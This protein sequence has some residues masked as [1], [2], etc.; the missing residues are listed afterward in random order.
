M[1]PRKVL[2]GIETADCLPAL[3]LAAEE[4]VRRGSGVHLMHVLPTL[5]ASHPQI[6]ELELVAGEVQRA[7]E[8]VVGEA[9]RTMQR[10]LPDDLVV[11]TE[12]RHGTVFSCLVEASAHACLLVLQHRDTRHDG[13]SHLLPT[14]HPVVA[15][16]H[17]AV[18]VVPQTWHS[19]ESVEPPLVL[20]GVDDG[21]RS[22]HVAQLAMAEAARRHARVRLVH[23]AKDRLG[24]VE[25]NDPREY[26]A[27]LR[28]AQREL[29]GDFSALTGS[30]PDVAVELEVVPEAPAT[31]LVAKARGAAVVVVGRGHRSLPF[32]KRLGPV[33][34]EVLRLAA[35]PVLVV[36]ETPPTPAAR[37]REP[38]RATIA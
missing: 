16:A 25:D 4:A 13:V 18:L 12:L 10:L 8:A 35:C 11:S 14:I 38:G 19:E 33:T 20:A 3:S 37:A 1:V 30:Q 21:T 27:W 24:G 2:V 7:G 32:V 17:C 22:A 6:D 5:D 28:R 23:G 29:E 36:D 31:A 9:A 34:G 26:A 15:S